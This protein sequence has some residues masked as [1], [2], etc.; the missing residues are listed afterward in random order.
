VQKMP[1]RVA[2]DSFHGRMAA[3]SNVLFNDEDLK[4]L[5]APS[6]R[7]PSLPPSLLC[8]VLLLQFHDDVS[9]DE[10]VQRLQFDLGWKVALNLPTDFA[11]FNPSSLTYFRRR[12]VEHGRNVMP[13][14]TSSP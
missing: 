14:T 7:R 6:N 8:G 1:H 5:Y 13:L 12:L 10:A 4:A 11:G 3:V 2:A 9:D